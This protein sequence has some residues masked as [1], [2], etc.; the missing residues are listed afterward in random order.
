MRKKHCEGASKIQD[1]LDTIEN[2]MQSDLKP[3]QLEAI[4]ELISKVKDNECKSYED[5]ERADS[6]R[7]FRQDVVIKVLGKVFELV[8]NFFDNDV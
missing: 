7:L 2:L 1:A 4:E 6:K 3:S 5:D 8:I